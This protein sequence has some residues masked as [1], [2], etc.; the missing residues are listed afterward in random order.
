MTNAV[1]TF[2]ISDQAKRD[3]KD[4]ENAVIGAFAGKLA[5]T[6]LPA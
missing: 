4:A 1:F 6:N 3:L 2:Y 5:S